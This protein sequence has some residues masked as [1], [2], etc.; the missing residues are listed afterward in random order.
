MHEF[1]TNV[2]DERD[3]YGIN[4]YGNKPRA[5]QC[6]AKFIIA[7]VSGVF[8]MTDNKIKNN[9]FNK[10]LYIIGHSRTFGPRT[11][12][13]TIVVA[14]SRI[15]NFSVKQCNR[16]NQWCRFDGIESSDNS[17]TSEDE[18]YDEYYY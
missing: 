2:N 11:R 1:I 12:Y 6:A 16:I 3:K 14:T 8:D 13:H 17:D 15:C 10:I 9:I 7:L 4:I 5:R 18:Y